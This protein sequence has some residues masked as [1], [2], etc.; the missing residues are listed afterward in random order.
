M[1]SSLSAQPMPLHGAALD[2]TFDVAGMDRLA[3]ILERSVT[4]IRDP[5]GLLVHAYVANMN[6]KARAGTLRIQRHFGIDRTTGPRCLQR[7]CSKGPAGR[8]HQ[9]WS[10]RERPCRPSIPP[11]PP[12]SPRSWRHVSSSLQPLFRP[13]GSLPFRWRKLTREPPVTWVK[14][15]DAVSA[16]TV[17][18]RLAGDAKDLGHHHSRSR[19][20]SHPMSGCRLRRGDRTVLI[21]V[22]LCGGFAADVEPKP[23][24]DAATMPFLDGAFQCGWL[25]TAA[26]T[27]SK[28]MLAW[29]T[30]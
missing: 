2:L 15:I 16:T 1:Y 27:C 14:P 11:P 10:R 24:R 25:F 26:N 18:T 21:D 5:A 3:D 29:L 28:P 30:P 7:N 23:T 22:D 12:G 17:R 6:A 8:M 20:G 4:S 13:P 19:R 9:H